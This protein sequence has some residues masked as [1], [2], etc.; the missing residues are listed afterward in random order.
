MIFSMTSFK[1]ST[2]TPPDTV[3]ILDRTKIPRWTDGQVWNEAVA[4]LL[5]PTNS[6]VVFRQHC[7]WVFVSWAYRNDRYRMQ[8]L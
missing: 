7:S 5:D 6:S 3:F 4:Y 8:L 1:L 2:T